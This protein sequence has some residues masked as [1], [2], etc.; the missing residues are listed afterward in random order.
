MA[1]KDFI[2]KIIEAILIKRKLGTCDV[3]CEETAKE[4]LKV[5]V[6]LDLLKNIED[7]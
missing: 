6:S 4:I 7:V 5:L 3:H 1:D 2:L